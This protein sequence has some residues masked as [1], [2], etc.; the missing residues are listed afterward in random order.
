MIE[1]KLFRN[2]VGHIVR[3]RAS[4]H[5]GLSERGTDTLCAAVSA[6][7][8]TAYLAIKDIG[9]NVAY[10][11]D[12]ESALFEFELGAD[13]K[14]YDEDVILRAMS[15]GLKDLES[16]FPQNLKTEELKCL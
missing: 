9:G 7:V 13:E 8:Q 5:S 15:V 14:R 2:S 16:G 6:L 4:G 12:S 3:V 11:R 10:S 1:V